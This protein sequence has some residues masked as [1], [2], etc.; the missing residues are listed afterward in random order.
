[1]DGGFQKNLM[2]GDSSICL[3]NTLKTIGR[4]SEFLWRAM[5]DMQTRAKD[6]PLAPDRFRHAAYSNHLCTLL[7]MADCVSFE[8][9]TLVVSMIYPTTSNVAEHVDV[10][11]DTVRG[12]TRTGAL[13]MCF[14]LDS[15]R[16]DFKLG[17]HFQVIGNF[18]RVIREYMD[19]EYP[20]RQERS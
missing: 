14:M 20:N 3:E 8:N 6:G 11:N 17:L 9:I 4:L 1:M 7:S 5:V 15:Q 12:Y 10:M 2:V 16:N 13:N 19:R 18:R